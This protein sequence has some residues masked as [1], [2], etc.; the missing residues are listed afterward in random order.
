MNELHKPVQF[1][2]RNDSVAVSV[3]TTRITEGKDFMLKAVSLAPYMCS[4]P[5]IDTA[6][7]EEEESD[8]KSG[9]K[10]GA[11]EIGLVLIL[12]ALLL[13]GIIFLR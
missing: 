9:S 8:S 6:T 7:A 10:F 1:I 3:D 12:L 13:V 5:N 2:L 4:V 11:T